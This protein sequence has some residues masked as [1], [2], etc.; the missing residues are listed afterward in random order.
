[1]DRLNE[2]LDRK[3]LDLEQKTA[4]ANEWARRYN[5]LN[6]QLE[7]TKKQLAAKGAAATL[8]QTAQDLLHEGKLEEAR[9]IFDRLIQSDEANV[10]RAA[11]DHFGRA[12]VF[13]LQFRLDEALPDYAK[14]YQY[15]PD[16]QR[17]AEAYAYALGQQ[18]DYPKAE[19][20]LQELLRH[21]RE[22]AAQNPAAYQPGLAWTL[23]SLG[24]VYDETNRFA[25]A[26]AAY[27]E[28]ADIWRAL[29]AQNPA[30]YRPDLAQTLNGLGVLY[31]ITNR[32][33]DAE[34]AVKEA[35]G[36]RP[37]GPTLR[38]RSP[39]WAFSTPT[40]TASPTPSPPTRR[41]PASGASWPRRTPP[42]IGP[43]SRWRSP[44]WENSTGR[45][46][47][48]PPPSPPTRR[49]PASSASWPC[50]TRPPT[51]PT[52][53]WRSASWENSTGRCCASPTPRPL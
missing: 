48:S 37:T 27:K 33:A 4:E 38:R 6:A 2:L 32:F 7:E 45:C 14:G 34:A 49:P 25:D 50:R 23:N 11:Q 5:D 44:A 26:E 15:R 35:A 52:S 12:S 40:P 21:R 9:A 17:F 36:I 42:P 10:N 29:A 1:L 39:T 18:K 43:A 28:A 8:V 22:L 24:L 19:S 46:G 16:D 47:A 31:G 13:A 30:A 20:V 41:P 53:R 51:G 3:D